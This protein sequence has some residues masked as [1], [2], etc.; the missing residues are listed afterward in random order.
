MWDC[1]DNMR[2]MF[3]SIKHS[4]ANALLLVL[5][6]EHSLLSLVVLDQIA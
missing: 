1:K 3:K 4:V 6:N 5:Q 2:M